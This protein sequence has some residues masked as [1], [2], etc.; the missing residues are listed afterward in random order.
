M[1][2]EN[3]AGFRRQSLAVFFNIRFGM[4]ET[5]STVV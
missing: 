4:P 5:G 1:V 2:G 3:R